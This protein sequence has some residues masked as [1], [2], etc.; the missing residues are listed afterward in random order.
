MSRGC[1]GLAGLALL[2][3]VC[4]SVGA[5]EPPALML[6]KSY[7]ADIEPRDYWVSEKL[8]GVRAY[9]DG[10]Q[11]ITRGG[12]PVHAPAWFTAGW[13]AQP[14]DGEL[15][16]GRGQFETLSATVRDAV[17]DDAAW[18]AVR[19]M[20]FDLPTHPGVFDERLAQLKLRVAAVGSASLHTVEQF[21]LDSRAALDARLAEVVAAGGEG[22]MLHRA[23]SHYQARRTD[24]L[25]K[26]KTYD[27]A[28]ARVVAY[29]PGAGKYTD[30]V[31]AL[32]VERADGLRFELGSGLSDAQRRE[33]PPLETWVTYRYNGST[34]A[35]VPRFARFLRVRDEL[36]PPDP[37]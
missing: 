15:W 28:E 16:S 8:D 22:L 23:D 33:P 37:R 32:V 9:W 18:R 20:V 6:A 13:P 21:R 35:G 26:L 36:P 29:Q 25:L 17:P 24:D 11:L 19:Y 5:T 12:H 30:Q 4:G 27:D 3:L 34:E 10:H 7:T 14:L 31:G 2:A 1:A